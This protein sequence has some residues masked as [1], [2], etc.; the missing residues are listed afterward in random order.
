MS[1]FPCIID[2]NA[3][4]AKWN[5]TQVTT[6]NYATPL[7][8]N[9]G[10]NYFLSPHFC[11]SQSNLSPSMKSPTTAKAGIFEMSRRWECLKYWNRGGMRPLCH[12]YLLFQISGGQCALWPP[13]LLLT[14][15]F[16][17]QASL[18]SPLSPDN[19]CWQ[20]PT[21]AESR[22]QPNKIGS[23]HSQIAVS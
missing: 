6:N 12:C 22:E 9:P 1:I 23:H 2:I 10:Q 16:S 3:P 5:I 8:C 21:C 18:L 20:E 15:G 11:V 14:T 19:L 17:L 4:C 7:P 13:P